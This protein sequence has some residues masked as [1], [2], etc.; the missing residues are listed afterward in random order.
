MPRPAIQSASHSSDVLKN[1]PI[2]E[3][4]PG[5]ILADFQ[6]LLDFV[7]TG[8]IATGGKNYRIPLAALAAS[9]NA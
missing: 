2:S 3:S 4:G 5:T 7:G 8:G 1:Q 6:T 9:T